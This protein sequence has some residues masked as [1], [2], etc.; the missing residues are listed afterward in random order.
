[1]CIWGILSCSDSR[2]CLKKGKIYM[3]DVML[4][5]L[6]LWPWVNTCQAC[7]I[8]TKIHI[9]VTK[10]YTIPIANCLT[11]SAPDKDTAS[12]HW[13]GGGL[14]GPPIKMTK[15]H[16]YVFKGFTRKKSGE[17]NFKMSDLP[18]VFKF[19]FSLVDS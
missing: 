11:L 12:D 9:F 19:F 13:R 10:C 4:F 16:I 18:F 5:D 1:M 2:N 15:W 7:D 17:R 3:L 6:V 14:R 8:A